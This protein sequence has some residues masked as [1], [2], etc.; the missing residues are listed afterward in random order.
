[1]R[2]IRVTG[3]TGTSNWFPLDSYSPA[4]ASVILTAAGA[5]VVEYT[6]DNPFLTS[7][8][9]VGEPLTLTSGAATVPAGARAVRM[10]GADPADVLNISQQGI[11]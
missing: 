4:Q 9:P 6:L 2:P 3:V 10:T 11:V 7:P 1:M 8:T 5:T